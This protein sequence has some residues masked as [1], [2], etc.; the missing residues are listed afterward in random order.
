MLLAA[1]NAL[2]FVVL[3]LWSF[4]VRRK[5]NARRALPDERLRLVV[6]SAP[7]GIVMVDAQGKIVLVNAQVEKLFGYRREELIGQAVEILLPKR[8][9]D[10]HIGQRDG[11][12]AKPKP[13]PMGAGRDL[14]ALTKDGHEIPIEIGL[15]PIKSETGA[16]MFV[17]AAIVDI[18]ERKRAK[19]K[20]EEALAAKS[21]FI[22]KV[23]HELRMPMT[24]IL[25][26]VDF[27][28][29]AP[30]GRLSA[31]QQEFLQMIKRN[32]V[33][34][35]EM[36]SNVLDFQ[37]LE[38]GKA[39]LLFQPQDINVLIQEVTGEF[40][41]LARERGLELQVQLA[42]SLPLILCDKEGI[43]RVVRN[44]LSNAIKFSKAGRVMAVTERGNNWIRV[45][46]QDEGPG[47]RVDD[48]P[49][50][51]ESFRQMDQGT[52]HVPKSTG[53]GLVVAKG[54][55][56]EHRGHIGVE[57]TLGKGS[58]FFIDLPIKER[59]RIAIWAKRS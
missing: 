43:R 52:G 7:T 4:R 28:M 39:D 14:T 16:G 41:P 58:K 3:I 9:R 45:V 11:Y 34:L 32:V 35:S 12:Y 53:L 19:A 2:I 47:I 46:V 8:F 29:E 51:F 38:S 24:A 49:R 40:L 59:R 27:V 50:L 26:G 18:T 54:I 15:S 22:D 23:S 37:K 42:E 10:A 30:D 13:R 31:D 17:M 36:I 55:V 21:E 6:E 57:S 1:V 48:I 44:L 56:E 20:I 25:A 33:R 5:S